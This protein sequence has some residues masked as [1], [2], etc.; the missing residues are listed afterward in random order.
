MSS[1][2][3]AGPSAADNPL[4]SPFASFHISA[5]DEAYA[6]V[7]AAAAAIPAT[8]ARLPPIADHPSSC[9]DLVASDSPK[10]AAGAAAAPVA[11]VSAAD[12]PDTADQMVNRLST[13]PNAAKNLAQAISD[14]S[15]AGSAA[16]LDQMSKGGSRVFRSTSGRKKR[17]I[18][19]RQ[20]GW[21][22]TTLDGS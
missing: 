1:G 20:V 14:V 15:K 2:T 11:P 12:L 7:S 18:P 5:T 10:L 8:G 3:S 19:L 16:D 6:D 22:D 4:Q 13:N 21:S 9:V 17:L